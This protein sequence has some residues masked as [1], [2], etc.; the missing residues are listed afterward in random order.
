MEYSSEP[1]IVTLK[2]DGP[3]VIEATY[4]DEKKRILYV[5]ESRDEGKTWVTV[6]EYDSKKYRITA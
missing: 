5:M 1:T 6:R 2:I 3:T 4:F